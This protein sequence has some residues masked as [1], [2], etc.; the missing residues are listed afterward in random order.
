M[1]KRNVFFVMGILKGRV[2]LAGKVGGGIDLDPNGLNSKKRKRKNLGNSEEG[3]VM[4]LYAKKREFPS[5]KYWKFVAGGGRHTMRLGRRY[6]MDWA[7]V[8]THIGNS[9]GFVGR[10]RRGSF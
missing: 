1:A 2:K 7:T 8:Q 6:A 3:E 5:S 4:G 9:D 10:A